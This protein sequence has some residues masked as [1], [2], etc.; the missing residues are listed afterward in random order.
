MLA[1]RA[2]L[3]VFRIWSS[4]SFCS[5]ALSVF[6][7]L[8]RAESPRPEP[9]TVVPETR[10]WELGDRGRTRAR[11]DEGRAHTLDPRKVS[12]AERP[13]EPSPR[14]DRS[15]PMV[16]DVDSWRCSLIYE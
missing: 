8:L 12:I 15:A 6:A 16:V 3:I 9:P 14:P 7:A 4:T 10:P 2:L 13:S 11:V 1:A 5:A